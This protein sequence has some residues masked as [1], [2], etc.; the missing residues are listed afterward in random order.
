MPGSQIPLILVVTSVKVSC[1]QSVCGNSVIF[2][3]NGDLHCGEFKRKLYL[4]TVWILLLS[5]NVLRKQYYVITVA[6]CEC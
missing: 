1:S 6:D 3:H 2:I 4:G 5:V